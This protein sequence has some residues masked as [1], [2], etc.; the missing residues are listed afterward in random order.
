MSGM[1]ENVFCPMM[2]TVIETG[3]CD[4]LQMIADD[5]I[6]PTVDEEHLTESDFAMCRE[7]K[8]RIDPSL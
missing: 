4:E 6:T 5:A 8:K 3:Y 1:I 7:C 2:K